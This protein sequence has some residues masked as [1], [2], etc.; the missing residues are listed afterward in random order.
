M[1]ETGNATPDERHELT[2]REVRE[3]ENARWTAHAEMHAMTLLH[4]RET[5]LQ[6]AATTTGLSAKVTE[7]AEVHRQNHEREHETAQLAITKAETGVEARFAAAAKGVEV[8]NGVIDSV[9]GELNRWRNRTEGAGASLRPMLMAA[10]GIGG[11]VAA[12]LIERAV[13]R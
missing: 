5:A 3:Y 10:I 6:L 8:H 7:L 11:A 13:G 9:L 12:F 4:E 1:S 2:T